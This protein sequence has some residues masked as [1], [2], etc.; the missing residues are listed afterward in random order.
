MEA[1]AES[2]VG[3][4]RHIEISEQVAHILGK[5]PGA[6]SELLDSLRKAEKQNYNTE[7]TTLLYKLKGKKHKDKKRSMT[8]RLAWFK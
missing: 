1:E 4:W 3:R 6:L 8:S 2:P 7:S 5:A